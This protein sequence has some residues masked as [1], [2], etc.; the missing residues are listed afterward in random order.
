MA[1]VREFQWGCGDFCGPA[2]FVDKGVLSM[3]KREV[4]ALFVIELG[5]LGRLRFSESMLVGESGK[6]G[7]GCVPIG[8]PSRGI[9]EIAILPGVFRRQLFP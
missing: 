5:M 2:R 4:E 6:F 9:S 3:M 7:P 1:P 8:G